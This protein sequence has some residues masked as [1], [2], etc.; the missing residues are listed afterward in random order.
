MPFTISHAIAVFPFR[1]ISDKYLSMT[2]LIAGSMAPDFEFFL[3]VTLYGNVSHTWLG[4]F[5]FDFPVA[6]AIAVLFQWVIKVQLIDNMPLMLKRRLIKYR[7][8]DWL[9]YFK[10]HFIV[11]LFSALIG[12]LTHFVWDNL[13]HEP[14]YI[15]SIYFDFLLTPIPLLKNIVPLY[16]VLQIFSSF[17]G[18]VVILFT[19]WRLPI[20]RGTATLHIN[21]SR[22]WAMV[23]S[24]TLI[25]IFLRYLIGV[26]TYKPFGQIIVISIS[27][28]LFSLLFV[29]S[30]FKWLKSN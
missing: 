16:H 6:V 18:I 30:Y 28:S 9:K 17:I 13:T 8:I 22:Y 5:I 27:T 21:K 7:D 14:G 26:P 23:F 29:S 10:K 20:H 24:L 3:R 2:G 25:L 11:V 19:V 15:S 4:F 1:R 12:I